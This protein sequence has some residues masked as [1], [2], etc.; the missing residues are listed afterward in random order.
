MFTKT[1]AITLLAFAAILASCATTSRTMPSYPSGP[2]KPGWDEAALSRA[3]ESFYTSRDM[4]AAGR[5]VEEAT[6]TVRLMV[7]FLPNFP[8][9]IALDAGISAI[10]AAAKG[11]KP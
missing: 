9:K 5:A 4:A 7:S 8:G 10:V 2:A 3:V 11:E 6:N 1:K